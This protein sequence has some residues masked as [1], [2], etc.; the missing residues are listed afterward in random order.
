MRFHGTIASIWILSLLIAI[1]GCGTSTPATPTTLTTS[2]P[3]TKV[4]KWTWE[5]GSNTV[6]SNNTG[7]SGVYGTLGIAAASN[8][9][10]GRESAVSWTD[11]SGNLW[12]FGGD[13]YDST[14]KY[15]Y[16]NDLWEFNPAS[17]EWTWVSGANS[18]GVYGGQS[19]V[20]GT[21]GVA[22]ASNV[23][24]GRVHAVSWI[25]SSGNLWLFGGGGYDS[26]G[27]SGELNDLWEFDPST[28]E[29][30]W[31]SGANA[32]GSRNGGASGVY[33]T[34]GVAAASNV[35]GGRQSAV[36]WTDSSGNLWL[37]GGSGFDS[38]GEK[39]YLN[40]LWEFDPSTKEWTW[41][42]G[43]NTVGSA[44]IGAFGV[45]G[46]LGVAAVGNVP[47]GRQSAVSWTDSSGNLWLSGGFGFDSTGEEGNLNDLWEFNPATKKWTWVSGAN[48]LGLYDGQSGV[49]GTLGVAA[50]GNVP[51]GR[52]GAVSWI[53]SSGTLWLLGGGG[54]DST[55]EDGYLNDLWEFGPST[56]EWTW[57][58]GSYS[59]GT[60]F[61]GAMGVYGTLGVAAVYNVPGERANAVS[62]TDSSGNLW[63]FGGF[64]VDST[65][66]YGSLNDLWKYQ[67]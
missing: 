36:S 15:G 57:V 45:Y 26:K 64:G 47:G 5:S 61:I 7:V 52:S 55:G 42:S 53:D 21:L 65:G 50:A 49:Y 59:I 44:Y 51:G 11:S 4:N 20:Y 14:G 58:G 39:R 28:K 19:G 6:G 27:I 8:V 32:V 9:P 34:L 24:G 60:A 33:G 37:F 12:L 46:I 67:P 30:T 35:P 56:K 41:V 62:W 23:P 25:D 10:C 17:K 1:T 16:L 54:F 48:T 66:N 29:W 31:V 2:T 18:S 38:T 43:A 63:L 13:G 22:A 40:D 3:P